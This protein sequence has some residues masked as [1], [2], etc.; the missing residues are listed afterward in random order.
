MQVDFLAAADKTRLTKTHI[1]TAKGVETRNYPQVRK[2]FSQRA[3]FD[4]PQELYAI[5]SVHAELGNCMLKGLL[6][7][8]IRNESRA[9]LTT[10]NAATNWVLLDF[11]F[12]TGWANVDEA[13]AEI[14]PE[15]ADKTYIW[16][17]SASAGI[18]GQ[19]RLRGHLW[20]L[21][22]GQIKPSRLKAWLRERNLTIPGLRARAK[23]AA[24]GTSV[25]WA[26]DITSCQNDRLIYI[27]P[28]DCIDLEDPLKERIVLVNKGEYLAPVP[29][30]ELTD[31]EL[32]TE[33]DTLIKE[34]R[35]KEGLPEKVGLVR[36]FGGVPILTNP[37]QC[38]ITG[39]RGNDKFTYINLNGGD[40]WG[41]Y[42]YTKEPEIVHNFKGE[43]AVRLKDIAPE[44]YLRKKLELRREQF[45]NIIPYVFRDRETDTYYNVIY[46]PAEDFAEVR[47]AGSKAKLADFLGNHG[48]PAPKFIP[49]WE[50]VF[51]PTCPTIIDPE[52]RWINR[53][54]PTPFIRYAFDRI[55]PKG[56]PPVINKLLDSLCAEDDKVKAHFLNWLAFIFQ[57]RERTQTAWVFHG[58]TGT[59][60]GQFYARVLRPL[61]G[62][63]QTVEWKIQTLEEKFNAELETTC[64]LWLD[65]FKYDDTKNGDLIMSKLK[66]LITEDE[67]TIRGMQRNSRQAPNFNNII[68]ADNRACP[69]TLPENDRRFNI[70]PL[71]ENQLIITEE[72]L[73]SINNELWNFATYL[74]HYNVNRAQARTV[75][76]NDARLQMIGASRT[77]IENF[78][79]AINAGDLRW[80]AEQMTPEPSGDFIAVYQSFEAEII[81]WAEEIDQSKH[82]PD[83]IKLSRESIRELYR[84]TVERHAPQAAKFTRLCHLH[85]LDMRPV[86]INGRTTTGAVIKRTNDFE[87]VSEVLK[88]ATKRNLTVIQGGRSE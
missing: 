2:F 58:T 11:D 42:F 10:P 17:H 30:I 67:I 63:K 37:D 55:K 24:T 75:L 40:S 6:D 33:T 12:H 5:I 76:K 68:I 54:E 9:G 22:K 4:T 20:M 66:N 60:K 50:M 73:K 62:R 31:L 8:P 7:R 41:Y 32:E 77:S 74:A 26:L 56:I 43:P 46:R 85:G 44:Y 13:L 80:F 27:A 34:L 51:D 25:R 61:F 21:L 87:V 57:T 15:W 29:R 79:L 84:Y 18:R 65:E 72:E 71:Q 70:A 83:P 69:I 88:Y 52:N 48:A 78:F 23:L 38:I 28:P 82:L 86:N 3:V 45:P 19:A 1:Q 59:G 53:Y 16:Q 64:I 36:K 35:A 81:K 14:V 49:D 47:A 39:E